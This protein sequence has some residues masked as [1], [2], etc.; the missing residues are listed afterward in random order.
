M[1][2]TE[3]VNGGSKMNERFYTLPAEKQQVTAVSLFSQQIKPF[4]KRTKRF[5]MLFRKAIV[6]ISV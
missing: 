5:A 6:S 4:T 3:T 2:L 1:V